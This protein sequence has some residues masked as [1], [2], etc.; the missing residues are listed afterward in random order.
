MLRSDLK[1][2]AQRSLCAGSV[3]TY[4]AIGICGDVVDWLQKNP[5]K[6]GVMQP[7]LTETF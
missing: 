1:D 5:T 3:V 2:F 6:V 4:R 7:S